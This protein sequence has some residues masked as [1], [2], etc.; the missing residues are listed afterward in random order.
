M[1]GG[2]AVAILGPTASG[3]TELGIALAGELDGEIVSV[4]SRQA[5]RGMEVGT[6]APTPEQRAAV[7]HHGVAFLAPGERYGAGRFARLA[8]SWIREIRHRGREPLLVGGTGL[9]YRALVQPVFREPSL[10]PERRRRLGRW[11]AEAG[12]ERVGA[13][14]RAVDPE[15]A[16]RLQRLDPQRAARALEVAWLTGRRLSWWQEHGPPEALPVPARAFVLELSADAHRARIAARAERMLGSG[17]AEEVRALRDDAPEPGAPWM[18]ALGYTAVAEWTGGGIS[19][20][21]ALARIV[22]DTWTYARRQRT[23]FRHQLPAETVRIDATRPAGE[24]I[25]R[26]LVAC[27]AAGEERRS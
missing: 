8:R 13:W 18:G 15:L 26:V 22:R 17:W 21:E 16:A 7:P 2:P 9:F 4:D 12:P 24:Q 1:G 5:Y 6:A 3:K 27:R 14:A 19:R 25:R 10:D 20:G 11:L 23:W